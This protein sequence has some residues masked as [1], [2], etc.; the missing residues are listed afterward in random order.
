MC[1]RFCSDICIRKMAHTRRHTYTHKGKHAEV[2]ACNTYMHTMKNYTNTET[3]AHTDAR[4]R[5]CVLTSC[6]VELSFS[7]FVC[8]ANVES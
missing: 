1:L 5:M 4:T 7:P 3:H 2:S 8:A 6:V